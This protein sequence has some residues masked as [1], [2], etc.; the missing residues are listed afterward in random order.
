[1]M[2]NLKQIGLAVHNYNDAQGG[3]PPAELAPGFLT[4]WALIF[5]YIEQDNLARELDYT[6]PTD[7]TS[8]IG[9]WGSYTLPPAMESAGNAN[10]GVLCGKAKGISLYLCPTRRT[11]PAENVIY[12]GTFWSTPV[13]DYAILTCPTGG[14]NSQ[15]EWS[16]EYHPSQQMQTL[17]IAK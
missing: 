5:P 16:F 17:R 12:G 4:F 7:G 10:M 2:N 9:D 3:L 13:G 14:A 11:A 6:M 8:G 15:G 1:C